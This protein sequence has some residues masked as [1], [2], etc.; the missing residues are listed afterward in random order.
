MVQ[1]Q[2]CMREAEVYRKKEDEKKEFTLSSLLLEPTV[3]IHK[4]LSYFRV[5]CC[6]LASSSS[7]L[8]PLF[9]LC[10]TS[11]DVADHPVDRKYWPTRP[12]TIPTTRTWT[13]CRST[14]ARYSPFCRGKECE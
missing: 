8:P 5:R 4:Y 13:R 1:T 3:R 11:N 10:P 6:L 2:E 14:C 12:R 7:S 9:C